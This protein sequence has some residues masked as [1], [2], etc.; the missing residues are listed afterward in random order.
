M[1]NRSGRS[2]QML[3]SLFC[4]GVQRS[5]LHRGLRGE[6]LEM[7]HM[8][9]GD[10]YLPFHNDLIPEDTNGDYNISALD[11]LL[12][13]NAINAGQSGALSGPGIGKADGPLVDVSGDNS[14][15]ALDALRIVNRLNGE[16]EVGDIVGFTFELTDRNGNP[17]PAGGSPSSSVASVGQLVQLKAFVQD[18]RGFNAQGVFTA[19]LDINYSDASKFELNVG[20]VQSFKYFFDK[21][22]T[23]NTTSNFKFTFDGQTTAPVSLFSGSSPRSAVAVGNAIQAALEALPNIG[24]GNVIVRRDAVTTAADQ[25]ADRKR[26]SFDIIFVNDMAGKNVSLITVDAS[27]IVMQPGQTLDFELVDKSPADPNNPASVTAAFFFSDEFTTGRNAELGTEGGVPQF[28][29]VGATGGLGTPKDPADR[30]LFFT[31]TLKAKAA[32]SVTFTPNPAEEFPA[33]ETLVFPKDTVPTS[34]IEYGSPFTLVIASSLVA[35]N[36]AFTVVEDAATAEFNLTANDQLIKGTSFTITAVGASS[37]GGIITTS[38]DGKKIN[39]RPAANFFGS[40]TFTYTITNNLGDTATATVTMTVTAV[41]D[42]ISVPNQTGTTNLGRPLVLTTAQLTA[43]G[44]VGPGEG[45]VQTLSVVSATSPSASGGIVVLANGSVTYTPAAGFSGTDTFTVVVTDNGLTN[46]VAD[47]KSQ[48]VTVTVTVTN[49]AP[50]AVD[51]PSETVDEESAGNVLLVL[52]NDTAGANDVNDALTVTAVTDSPNGTVTISANGLSV[53]YTPDA[54]FVGTDTFTYTVRDRGGLTDTATVTVNVEPTVLPRARN[55]Q[56]S[57]SEDSTGVVINVLSN[58]R[59]TE[60]SKAVLLSVGTAANG[61]VT[62]QDNSTPNDRRD[63]TVRYVPNA[64]FSGTDTFTYVMNETPSNGVNSTGTVTVTVVA[65]NDP[66]IL[67]NDNVAATEDTPVTFS[68]TVLLSNDSP[69]VGETANQALSIIAVQ[70]VT[71]GGGSVALNGGNVVY[72]PAANF[73]GNFVFTYTATDNGTPALTGTATVTIA[74]A[75]VNDVPVVGNNSDTTSEDTAK[76]IQASVLLANDTPGAASAT[77]EAGQTLTIVAAATSA[78]GGVVTL[79]A[80]GGSITYTP[81]AN[82]FGTDTFTYTVRDNGAPTAETVG[83]VTMTVTAVNDAP[84][85]SVDTVTAFKGVPLTINATTLLTNDS[86]GPANESTQQLTVTT[87]SGATNGTVSLANGQIV[88]TPAAGFTGAA[89]FQYTVRDNGQ[90][91]GAED[92][93]TATST[94][95]ITVQEFVPSQIS[96]IVYVDETNDGIKQDAERALG[97]VVVT[98]VG[99]AFGQT[100]NLSYTTPADGSYS[101]SNLAPGMYTVSFANPAMLLDGID[102]AGSLGDADGVANNNAFGINIASPGGANAVNYNFAVAGVTSGYSTIM[103]RL[104]SRYFAAGSALANNGL[105]ATTSAD[106][107]Q[108][109]FAKLNGFDNVVFAE[110]T[111]NS[112]GTEAVLTIVESNH[113]VFVARLGKGKFLTMHDD[114]GNTIIRILGGRAQLQFT[115][116]DLSAPPVLSANRFLDAVDQFFEQQGWKRD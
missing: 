35:N 2:G 98:L 45:A 42:A 63:D 95:N 92:F 60:T 12:V 81:A 16:G 99:T 57:T 26:F 8:M 76:T 32:G 17:L 6:S 70:A 14:L 111:L 112:A 72:T 4:K 115:K 1:K 86:P 24:P 62:V 31:V 15:S 36:D 25:T 44:N 74:V 7:R 22:N 75:A 82:F 80:G 90:T 27:G 71:S 53:V 29:E 101:F 48:T 116:I 77:D 55:D 100:V 113:D 49:D 33:H 46:G 79:A 97:G 59:T 28:D 94:V 10:S 52:A 50:N 64:N 110:V 21:I 43:G 65:V 96:G 41:N 108:E 91:D 102:T 88:F 56:A 78:R 40:D 47:P 83:T 34:L 38:G 107:S 66:P 58:D 61:T 54:G 87:V 20:E 103:E 51:D 18:L 3:K 67:A 106:G 11:A 9:A 105:Y 30:K 68:S 93:K 84:T 114:L 5:S 109:W 19:F 69:G 23:T 85:A 73:N 39:Y 104:A 13:I 37:A 89:S